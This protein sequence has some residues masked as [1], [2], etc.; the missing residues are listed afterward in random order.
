MRRNFLCIGFVFAAVIVSGAWR[1]ALRTSADEIT[2]P[3]TVPATRVA[4]V[5]LSRI[6]QNHAEFKRETDVLRRDVEAAERSLKTHQAELQAAADAMAAL[7]KGSSE[8]KRLEEQID[9]DM[10][11][12]KV[13][14]E[15]QKKDFFEREA[16]LY[17]K[18]YRE[19][20]ADVARYSKA[21]GINLVMRC[22]ADPYDTNDLQEL[23]KELNKAVLYQDGIDI[24][25]EIL[26]L[27][28]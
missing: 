3:A 4:T 25:D 19:V 17:L 5:D 18:V 26:A 9:K 6:F 21:H 7:P 12:L 16:A 27:V 13:T 2:E 15:K 1:D 22:H 8:S 28:N 11:D 20:M 23:Q 24:T 10:A 14:V